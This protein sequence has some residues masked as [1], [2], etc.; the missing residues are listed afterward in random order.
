MHKGQCFVINMEKAL[1]LTDGDFEL[2]KELFELYL[3]DYP[4]R[5]TEIKEGLQAEDYE[6]VRNA[7][8]SL[9]GA[10]LN[11]GFESISEIAKE[12]E[13]YAEKDDREKIYGVLNQL[14]RELL[15]LEEFISIQAWMS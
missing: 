1:E 7:A 10:S 14:E 6:K 13:S 8:H 3:E 11:L 15:S 12:L 4:K 9:K 5:L 2:L